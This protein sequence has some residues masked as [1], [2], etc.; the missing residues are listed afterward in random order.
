MTARISF[1]D[2]ETAFDTSLMEWRLTH[3]DIGV[4]DGRASSSYPLAEVRVVIA[5]LFT[6]NRPNTTRLHVSVF[7]LGTTCWL[8]P[9]AYRIW[10]CITERG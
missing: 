9:H 5:P 3:H 1:I 6:I 8:K 2:L 7:K 4:K 10:E